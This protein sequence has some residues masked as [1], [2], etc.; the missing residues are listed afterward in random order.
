[1]ARWSSPCRL[2]VVTLVALWCSSRDEH[3]FAQCKRCP[4]LF[5]STTAASVQSD[6]LPQHSDQG[7][8]P[9]GR[10]VNRQHQR[11]IDP[12]Q[13]TDA[14]ATDAMAF[15]TAAAPALPLGRDAPVP[16]TPAF[17]IDELFNIMGAEPSAQ[18]AEVAALRADMLAQL[19]MR[20]STPR[21]NDTTAFLKLISVFGSGLLL[22]AAVFVAVTWPARLRA[23]LAS[24]RGAMNLSQRAFATIPAVSR[25][26]WLR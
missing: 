9:H 23:A 18:P 1:M 7:T 10:Y 3:A 22:I 16:A 2:L 24:L 8:G 26:G 17:R 19:P 13:V 6:E 11:H 4:E 5:A 20:Q 21:T 12:A 14:G 15:A 25:C